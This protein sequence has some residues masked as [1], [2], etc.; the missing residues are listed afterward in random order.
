MSLFTQAIVADMYGLRLDMAQLADALGIAV[1]TI[2]NRI[3][4][5]TFDIPTYIDGKARWCDYRDVAAYLDRV[6]DAMEERHS[7]RVDRVLTWVPIAK[8]CA[9]TGEALADIKK[10][11]RTGDWLTDRHAR[12]PAGATGMWINLKAVND[13]AAGIKPSSLHGDDS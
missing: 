9:D 12:V 11:L 8:Y 3:G 1:N 4:Q 10:R 13:W 2:Y 6:R 5:G 7:N